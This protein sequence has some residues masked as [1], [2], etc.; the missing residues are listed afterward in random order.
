MSDELPPMTKEDFNSLMKAAFQQGNRSGKSHTQ[1]W[2]V[3]DF[4]IP[5][6]AP[7]NYAQLCDQAKQLMVIS[8]KPSICIHPLNDQTNLEAVQISE[9]EFRNTLRRPV[10]HQPCLA[11]PDTYYLLPT[12]PTQ[13][14]GDKIEEW[15]EE[16]YFPTFDGRK[17]I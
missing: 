16:E 7:P 2:H 4:G 17:A 5:Q 12:C 13:Q 10:R 1:Y 14:D 15:Y 6:P 3:D 9:T 8:E 11:Q